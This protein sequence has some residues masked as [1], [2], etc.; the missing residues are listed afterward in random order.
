[1]DRFRACFSD[2]E[3]PRRGNARRH[4]LL[5]MLFIALA[6]NLCGAES[7]VD[8]ADFAEAKA[9]L[10]RR[11]LRLDNGVPSHDTFSRLFRLLDPAQF[12]AGF[13]RFLASFGRAQSAV[14]ALDGKTLRRS[15]DRA[16]TAS[17]LHLIS[18]WACEEH[19]VLGQIKVDP[20]SNEIAALP[21]LIELLSLDGA[22][23]TL[24]AM[25]CQRARAEAIL[26]RGGDYLMTVKTNQPTLHQDIRLLLEDPAATPDDSDQ[27]VD[28]D[29]GRI[30]TRR[31]AV[32]HDIAWLQQAHR[33]PGLQTI[34]KLTASREINGKTTSATRFYIA[35]RKLSAAQLN[36]LARAHW[37]IENQ[38][39]WVLD[40]V[41]TEDQARARKDN[42]PENL[43]LMRRFAL[44]IIKENKDK[45]SNRLKFK[46]AGW[47]DKFLLKLISQIA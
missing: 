21:A 39:H 18:A 36:D 29:H 7:C 37:S 10:L 23:V 6:A 25:H 44:N 31:A 1:M 2:L 26:A 42:A 4:D 12:H 8:M 13:Q 5:E 17:P 43:A 32:V 38:L 24:D 3:D 27:S 16:A 20:R 30:E 33:W 22:T 41:M 9:G 40:V 11:I 35:S 46:R 45:G 19:L 47:D 34:A 15:F 28:G 14:V